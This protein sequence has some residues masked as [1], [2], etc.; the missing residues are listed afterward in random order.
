MIDDM[1][2]PYPVAIMMACCE[3]GRIT[4]RN[5]AIKSTKRMKSATA[6]ASETMPDPNTATGTQKQMTRTRSQMADTQDSGLVAVNSAA[7][8]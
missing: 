1:M 4:R 8:S 6:A 3:S 5:A 2:A 7:T